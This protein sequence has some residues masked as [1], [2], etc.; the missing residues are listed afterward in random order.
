MTLALADLEACFEGVIPS[1]ICT[2]DADGVPNISYLS[3]VVMVDD[4]HV[5]LSNQFFA[6]TSSNIRLNPQATLLLVDGRSGEQFRLE[7]IFAYSLETGPLFD[8]LSLQ[9]DAS[10]AQ[11]GMSGVMRL[12][13]L[14]VFRVV[15]ID[16][17]P[18]LTVVGAR[19]RE[20]RGRLAAV[21]S[22][23]DAITLETEADGI[24]DA[25]LKGIRDRLG[26]HHG[27]LLHLYQER[28]QLVVIGSL[29]YQPSGIGA[30]APSGEGIISAAA[31]S[32]RIVKVSDASRLQRFTAAVRDSSSDENRTR[33]IHL[34]SIDDSMSQIAVPV[35][36]GNTTRGV[37]F[38]ESRERLAF[39]REDEATLTVV[40]RTVALALA[41]SERLSQETEPDSKAGPIDVG[42]AGVV[43]V[44]HHAFDDSVFIDGAYV[45]K[46][47]AGRLLVSM[48]EQHLANGRTEFTNREIRLDAGLRLPDLKDNLETR[49][50][51]LRRRLDEKQM[52]IRIV[53][54]GRGRLALRLDGRVQ[55]ARAGG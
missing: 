19:P 48:L 52:P 23:V 32:G 28:D 11:N 41:L 46:G 30:D 39:T 15:T 36:V 7:L 12:R 35:S 53:P 18:A 44:Q 13:N 29:G 16:A 24:I 33:A 9:L 17:F 2:A 3:H 54:L 6:K 43:T 8:H 22:I 42:L 34:P 37:L 51:L 55:V 10:S 27:L 5:G 38:L 47:V 21:A 4:G 25:A 26:Y 49:L 40:A 20:D 45:I 1:I 50:L 31:A 14:D